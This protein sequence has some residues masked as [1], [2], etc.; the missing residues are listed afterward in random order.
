MQ[1]FWRNATT[2]ISALTLSAALA[3]TAEPAQKA[4]A[5]LTSPPKA[6]ASKPANIPKPAAK[7]KLVD[8]NSATYGQLKAIPGLGAAYSARIPA[9]RPYANKSQLVSRKVLPES[10]Y[11]KVK[12]RLIAKQPKK[13]DKTPYL[14]Q[15][16]HARKNSPSL[17]Q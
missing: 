12:D 15:S 13:V 9:N 8:I 1:R 14:P 16:P 7:Q 6:G 5:G 4:A 10:V 2:Y 17:P 11:A 3:W